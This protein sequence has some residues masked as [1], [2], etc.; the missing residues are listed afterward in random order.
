MYGTCLMMRFAMMEDQ[1]DREEVL[2]FLKGLAD[3]LDGFVSGVE[4]RQGLRG[5]DQAAERTPAESA[6]STAQCLYGAEPPRIHLG[7]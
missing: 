7:V 5:L 4:R 1:V 2:A 6:V 3:A